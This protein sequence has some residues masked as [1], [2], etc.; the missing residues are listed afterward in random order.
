[1]P[2]MS[3]ISWDLLFF[4]KIDTKTKFGTE[5]TKMTILTTVDKGAYIA[6][7]AKDNKHWI[8]T[9]DFAENW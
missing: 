9:M 1:M 5:N 4:V 7:V 3:K 2:G 8:S 6:T